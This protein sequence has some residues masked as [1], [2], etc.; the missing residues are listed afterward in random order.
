MAS[1]IHLVFGDLD[2]MYNSTKPIIVDLINPGQPAS[3]IFLHLIHIQLNWVRRTTRS[4]RL[5]TRE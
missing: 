4:K 3:L 1:P 2:L 5:I